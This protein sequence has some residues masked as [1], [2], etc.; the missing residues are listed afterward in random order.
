MRIEV[1][2]D[3]QLGDG[4]AERTARVRSRVHDDVLRIVAPPG[5][6]GPVDDASGLLGMFLLPAMVLRE[7]LTVDGVVSP[8]LLRRVEDVQTIWRT[9][10]PHLAEVDVRVTEVERDPPPPAGRQVGC[11]FSRGVDS[12]YSATLERGEGDDPTMLVYLLGIDHAQS[13]AT[14]EV[15]ARLAGSAA[16]AVGLPLTV[17]R[18]NVRELTDRVH[19]WGDCHGSVLAGT[20]TLLGGTLRRMVIPSTYSVSAL[21]PYGSSPLVD[22]RFS[23]RSVQVEHDDVLFSRV[24]KIFALAGQRPDLLAHLRVCWESDRADNCGRCTKC[25]HT[26]AGL[27]ARGVLDQAAL[28]P[29][30]IDVDRVAAMRLTGVQQLVNFTE[31]ARTL[32]SDGL[33]G[34]V[35]RALLTA[36]ERSVRPVGV[37]RWRLVIDRLRG[38]RP[39]VRGAW[40][41]PDPT[42]PWRYTSE[43]VQLLDRGRPDRPVQPGAQ[44]PRSGPPLYPT[45]SARRAA[46]TGR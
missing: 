8:G 31:T 5:V 4:T 19:G 2:G 42:F 33:Q 13:P 24:G 29:D 41:P 9:W 37:E 38:R 7:G 10:N 14:R 23:T 36:V 25:L 6:L 26:M 32:E 34:E 16:A 22:H 11:Y 18:T 39:T 3:R 21:V 12:L 45:A 40:Q 27:L 46:G 28:F 15:D 20:A 30:T 43:L 17:V 1:I 35:K 44:H